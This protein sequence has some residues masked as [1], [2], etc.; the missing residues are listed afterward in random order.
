MKRRIAAFLCRTPRH[1]VEA[2]GCGKDCRSAMP[3]DRVPPMQQLSS[4]PW[5]DLLNA[6]QKEWRESEI[7]LGRDPD[8]YIEN[9]LREAGRWPLPGQASHHRH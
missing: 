6:L 5:L 1:F 9:V 4:P 2:N 8:S 7:Q 3:L